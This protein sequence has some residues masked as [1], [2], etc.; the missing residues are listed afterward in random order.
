LRKL[1]AF[2]ATA[3]LAACASIAPVSFVTTSLA[4]SDA[5]FA[6]VSRKLNEI[7]YT[8][9]NASKDAGFITAEHQTSG[10]ATAV[11]LNRKYRD[12]ITL[13][14][15]DDAGGATRKIRA[16][17]GQSEE[18][19]GLFG[20]ASKSTMKPSDQ[21]VADGKAILSACGTGA[22]TERTSAS[23]TSLGVSVGTR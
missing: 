22:I 4:P 11:L 21:G 7:G 16:T 13:S 20:N 3:G 15:F 19:A 1:L 9:T 17:V 5:S 23:R 12:V 8:V 10:L 6:C 18:A 2:I 14:I